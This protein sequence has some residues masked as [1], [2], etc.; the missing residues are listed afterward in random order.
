[1]KILHYYVVLS[2]IQLTLMEVQGN[3]QYPEY[4]QKE[5]IKNI[6]LNMK[7]KVKEDIH[8]NHL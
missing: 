8:N 1:M 2:L 7:K 5:L 3:G 6:R 4:G